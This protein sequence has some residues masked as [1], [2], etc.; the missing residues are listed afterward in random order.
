MTDSKFG[1]GH[2]LELIDGSAYIFRAYHALPPLTRKSDGLPVG[3]ISGFCNMVFK[4]V[5]D[6]KGADAPTHVAVIFD[7]KGKTFRSE[8]YPEYKAQRPPPPEDLGPQFDLMRD[9]TR[10]FNL[11]C[12][13]IEGYEADDIIAT[14]AEQ[15]RDAGGRVTIISS[16]KDLMQLVGGGV[17]MVDPM[18]NR[19]IGPEEVEEKFGVGPDKVIDVQSLSGDSV[20]NIPGAPGI[21][22]KTAAL[23]INEYGDLDNLLAHAD[24]IKQPKRR[25]TL[26][27]F[28]EQIRPANW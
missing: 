10:A 3:A 16:D 13:E 6:Q 18:K 15:A 2:H 8:I 20:D 26:V 22:I 12:I 1:K 24:D 14:L 23:L 28:A 4:M 27:N 17:E 5:E 21:G 9:A 11:P 19:R 7:H 25:E